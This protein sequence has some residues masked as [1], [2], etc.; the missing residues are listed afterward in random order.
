MLPRDDSE[1]VYGY[2]TVNSTRDHVK[3]GEE[4]WI[5]VAI[6]AEEILVQ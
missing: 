2:V 1:E 4:D 5:T 3:H 6:E